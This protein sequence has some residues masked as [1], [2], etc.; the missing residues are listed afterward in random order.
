MDRAAQHIRDVSQKLDALSTEAPIFILGDFNQCSLEQSL[1]TYNQYITFPPRKNSNRLSPLG[2]RDDGVYAE[3]MNSFYSRFDIDAFC[4]VIGDIKKST[5]TNGELVIEEED[6]LRVFQCTHVKKGF[7]PGGISGQVL[8]NCATQLSGLFRVIFQVSL[9]LQKIPTL[10]KTS[11]VIHLLDP[12][13]FAYGSGRGAEDA[14]FAKLCTL[15][16]LP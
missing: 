13:Q 3:D 16:S 5:K 4:S 6:V 1:P 12:L 7:C 2:G 11:T 9:S 10:W 15:S 14:N 8:K